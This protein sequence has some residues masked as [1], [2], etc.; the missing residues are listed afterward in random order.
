MRKR[1]WIFSGKHDDYID[2]P[3]SFQVLGLKIRALMKRS[4]DLAED[5]QLLTYENISIDIASKK[6]YRDGEEI[7][8]TGKEYELLEYMMRHPE[9]VL[10]KEKIFDEIWGVDCF[11]DV[12]SLNVHIRWL[13]EKLE[14]DPRNPRLIRT[15]WRVGYQFGG[16]GV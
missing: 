12:G 3:F 9:Q 13:R 7:Q 8:I 5:R 15:V 1:D 4:Y 2:K 10:K 11:S 6:V 14:E 16:S